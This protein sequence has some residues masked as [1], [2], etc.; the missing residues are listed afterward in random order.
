[1]GTLKEKAVQIRDETKICSN[2]SKRVGGVLVELVKLDEDKT[3]RIEAL[4]EKVG[5]LNDIID[6]LRLRVSPKKI[7][8][9]ASGG[10]EM[11]TVKSLI[12]WVVV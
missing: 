2:T 10:T 7:S 3:R 6:D 11:I 9:T 4:E 8:F 12:A 5:N 1:M